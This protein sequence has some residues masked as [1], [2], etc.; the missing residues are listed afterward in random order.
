MV[1][2]WSVNLFLPLSFPTFQKLPFVMFTH[3]G[4]PLFVAQLL[5]QLSSPYITFL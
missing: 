5:N 1:R 3:G 4:V 2:T